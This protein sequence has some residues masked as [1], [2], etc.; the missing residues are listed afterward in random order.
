MTKIKYV[1]RLHLVGRV[2]SRRKLAQAAGCGKSAVSDCLS[3]AAAAGLTT[4]DAVEKLTEEDLEQRLYPAA[5]RAPA[6]KARRPVPDWTKVREELA[7]RDH[8]VT[9]ALLWQEYKAQHPEGY[10]YSAVH[11]S[12]PALREEA[13]GRATAIAPGAVRSRSSTSAM[14]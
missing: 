1:L 4:W 8:Q 2:S 11:R 6:R 12:V 13:L 7:R 9:L 10:Q 14:G 3:R 5:G